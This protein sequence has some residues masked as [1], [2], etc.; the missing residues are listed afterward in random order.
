MDLQVNEEEGKW[1]DGWTIDYSV[2]GQMDEQRMNECW[3]SEGE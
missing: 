1:V 3:M 2:G